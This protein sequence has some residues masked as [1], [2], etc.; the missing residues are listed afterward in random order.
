MDAKSRGTLTLV[1]RRRRFFM[2]AKKITPVAFLASLIVVFFQQ[3][4]FTNLIL[5]RG[6]VLLYFYPYWHAAS[7]ALRAGQLPLWN[8]HLFMGAPLLANSQMGFYYPLNWPL[9]LALPVP[10]A[11]SATILLHVLIAGL[12]TFVLGRRRLGLNRSGAIAAAVLFALSGYLTAQVEHVNQLQGLAWLPWMLVA[13]GGALAA[14]D[15]RKRLLRTVSL[16]AFLAIQLLAG[17]TQT[18]FISVVALIGWLGARSV[19]ARV[20]RRRLTSAAWV[21]LLAGVLALLLA[22]AQVLPTLELAQFSSRQGGLAV[23]EVLSFSLHPLLLTRAL[24]PGYGDS[25]FT[26][27]VAYLP[28][29][30]VLLAFAAFRSKRRRRELVPAAVLAGVGFLLALGV[31]NP[32]YHLL[33]IIPPF[34]LFRAPSRWLVLYALGAAL[35]AGA[36]WQAAFDEDDQPEQRSFARQL[37]LAIG[38]LTLLLAWG[39]TAPW[40]KRFLPSGNEVN[41]TAPTIIA[42]ALWLIEAILASFVLARWRTK[43]G[44]VM[45][46]LVGLA[47][48]FW[49]AASLPYRNLTAPEAYFDLRPP[50]ARLLAEG[51]CL[52]IDTECEEP[53]GR[54]LSVSDIFFD[55]GDQAELGSIYGD[56]LSS[57]SLYDYTVAVKQ[58]E[59]IA[60][61]LSLQYGLSSVD[62][63]DG[64]VLPL[65]SY[66]EI[67]RLLLPDGARTTDGRLR[68]LLDGLPEDHWLDLFNSQYLITDKVG[69]LW[70]GGVFFDRQHQ[71]VLSAAAP[72]VEVGYVPDFEAAEIWLL[73]EDSPGWMKVELAT[74][75]SVVGR[76]LEQDE[77]LW[78]FE[79]PVEARPVAVRFAACPP[80]GEPSDCVNSWHIQAATLVANQGQYFRPLALG[81][82]R[83][84]HS[85]DVKIYEN[86]DVLPRAFL[87]YRWS[88][89]R[90]A[91][92]MVD[93]MADRDFDPAVNAVVLLDDPPSPPSVGRGLAVFST[94]ASDSVEIR[95]VTNET[96]LLVLT[97]GFYPGWEAR[98]D[99]ELEQIVQVDGMFRGVFVP[100]GEHEVSFT[101][102]PLSVYVGLMV[103]ALAWLA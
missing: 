18:S 73:S 40:L 91:G 82:H 5:A 75:D 34:N 101:F 4:A 89:A 53:S 84:I 36:G 39:A 69:D 87:V 48:M 77:G 30:A 54:L 94:Y 38:F 37:W 86:L 6:D 62:G 63:F 8:Q 61:N 51:E 64:G 93:M 43:F 81:Q 45:L 1:R 12:G 67:T 97:D 60:P 42:Y 27:Y 2:L 3:M 25:L 46:A 57:E 99:G 23:N 56:Q 21:S 11:V 90:S 22:A 68:E 26:E 47:A 59:I 66:S 103:S 50:A 14:G 71:Q 32:L 96:A 100:G 33:A 88:T 9:W 29:T 76:P 58:Q 102:R 44:A 83:L 16:G 65:S 70:R 13:A 92:E 15:Q 74:G 24:L 31:F 85:G 98:I 17:H 78:R 52:V 55:P 10:Y 49:G 72:I 28:I 79:L 7:E 19:L 35:L 80:G 20:R 95:V 41:I